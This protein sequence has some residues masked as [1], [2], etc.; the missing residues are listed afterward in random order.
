MRIIPVNLKHT[1]AAVGSFVLLAGMA[2]AEKAPPELMQMLRE[3]PAE[4]APRIAH[5]IEAHW[6]R[7]GSAAMDLLLSR[8]REAMADGDAR[9]AIEHLTALTDHAPVLPKGS[10]PGRR[11]IMEPISMAPRWMI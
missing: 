11:P 6:Q 3:A 10:M 4:E 9:L 2:V 1:V 5:E 8:G 7:S